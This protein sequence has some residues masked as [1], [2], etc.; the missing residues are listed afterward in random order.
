[1]DSQ[2]AVGRLVVVS[3]GS[4]VIGHREVAKGIVGRVADF[5]PHT[6]YSSVI[7]HKR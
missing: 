3:S 1:M 2:I 5:D 7:G 4:D 6:R